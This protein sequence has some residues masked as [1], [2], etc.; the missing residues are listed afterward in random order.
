MNRTDTL[1]GVIGY[2]ITPFHSDDTVNADLLGELVER[3]IEGGVHAIAPLGSTGVL[4]YLDD[5][6]RQLVT[7]ATISHV[8]GRVPVVVGVSS[9]TTERTIRHA[10]FAESA[11]TD[12]VMVLPMSYWTLTEDELLTHYREIDGAIDVPIVLYNN[13]ATSGID[14]SPEAIAELLELDN[15]TMVKESTGDVSRM[16]RLR[17]ICGEDVAF[18]N[19]SNPKALA[20]L[21]AGARGWCTAAPHIIPEL[22][23]AL[24]EAVERGDLDEARDLFYRQARFLNFIVEYGLPRTIS[25]ALKLLGT[26]VGPLR[27]PLSSITS[28]QREELA[29]ILS[30]MGRFD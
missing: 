23:V 14:I 15:V 2:P 6:E 5:D 24:Y 30:E 29:E 3:M 8:G 25:A 7:E 20:A 19:G 10:Q 13:P 17:Q 28:A 18:Y 26:E 22:N 11:G 21:A 27:A 4:P 16:Q 1:E 9:L 12:A